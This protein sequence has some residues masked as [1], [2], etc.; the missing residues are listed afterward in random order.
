MEIYEFKN[1]E[2]VSA[3]TLIKKFKHILDCERMGTFSFEENEY[4]WYIGVNVY[5]KIR[6][7]LD[8]Y[9]YPFSNVIDKFLGIDLKV[10]VPGFMPAT[11]IL[12]KKNSE[13]ITSDMISLSK[14]YNNIFK[15]DTPKKVIFNDPATIVY[16]K[17]GTKTVVKAEG[18]SF[19][20]E[21]GLAMAI[22][23]RHL[24][25]KG[26]YYDIFKEWLPKEKAKWKDPAEKF[27]SSCKH[28]SLDPSGM[29]ECL[30]CLEG[31]NLPNLEKAYE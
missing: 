26:N 20:P 28:F 4:E 10:F 22:A 31:E 21:K 19:D 30:E 25:N 8:L 5:M 16:W 2:D 17:D 18:E 29:R 3:E 27:C 7:T 14:T 1:M 23:K 11:I 12:D 6:N 24:G 15:K 13:R 9:L